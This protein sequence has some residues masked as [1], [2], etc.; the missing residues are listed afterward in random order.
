MRASSTQVPECD[1]H[2]HNTTGVSV[3]A[4]YLSPYATV[5]CFQHLDVILTRLQE[6]DTSQHHLPQPPKL[7]SVPARPFLAASVTVEEL[8]QCLQFSRRPQTRLLP[9]RFR[10]ASAPLPPLPLPLLPL[11]PPA[12]HRA[13]ILNLSVISLPQH[14]GNLPGSGR[15]VAAE[16][17]EAVHVGVRR[18]DE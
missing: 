6:P 9:R 3:K 11:S 10:L 4:V 17:E 8:Q 16:S 1:K 12:N 5:N 7:F 13:P 15:G 18:S 14:H 2:G